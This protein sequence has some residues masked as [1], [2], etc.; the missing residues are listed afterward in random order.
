MNRLSQSFLSFRARARLIAVWAALISCVLS[1]LLAD[2]ESDPPLQR[3]ITLKVENESRRE[4]LLR[5]FRYAGVKLEIDT[6][7]MAQS[8]L[9]LNQQVTREFDET[10]LHEVMMWLMEH[11]KHSDVYVTPYGDGWVLSSLNIRKARTDLYLPD[12]LKGERGIHATVDHRGA[13]QQV[14]IQI[15]MDEDRFRRLQELPALRELSLSVSEGLTANHLQHLSKL[16]SLQKVEFIGLKGDAGKLGD[17]A[18]AAIK[19][20]PSLQ[21]VSLNECGASDKGIEILAS[22]PLLRELIIYQE[23]RLTDASLRA[24][25]KMSQLKLLS[26]MTYVRNAEEGVAHFTPEGYRALNGMPNLENLNLTHAF[27]PPSIDGVHFPK[28]R[29]VSLF[30][31]NANDTAASQLVT[32]QTLRSVRFDRD[33]LTDDGLRQLARLSGLRTLSFQSNNVSPEGLAELR[34]LPQLSELEIRT[35]AN[36][37]ALEQIVAISSLQRLTLSSM[38]TLHGFQKLKALKSLTSLQLNGTASEVGLMSVAELKQLKRL[39]LHLEGLTQSRLDVLR[40]EMPE[41]VIDAMRPLTGGGFPM[42]PPLN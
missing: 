26:L 37:R 21:H 30:G 33:A 3:R 4:A 41:T 14:S 16:E 42:E 10:P 13:V 9:D 18:I 20:L 27:Y 5:A 34:N 11:P 12:W 39:T 31:P 1:P 19:D 8:A 22:M 15:A 6:V 32:M 2:D 7:G 28:L 36:D 35:P 24:I 40:K 23:S 38:P 17:V 29:T 25:G